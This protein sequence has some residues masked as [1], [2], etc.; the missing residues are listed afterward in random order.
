MMNNLRQLIHDGEGL[1]IEFK[2]CEN[3]LTSNIY[4]TVSA[5]SNRMADT[6]YLAL[7]TTAKSAA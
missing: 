4:E 7:K 1:T 2:R 3:D 6:Y 5:F